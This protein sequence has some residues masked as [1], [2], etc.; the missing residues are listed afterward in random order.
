[1]SDK[2]EDKLLD[3]NYD[4]IEEYDNDL[5]RWWVYLFY[6]TIIF[7]VIYTIYYHVGG[8]GLSAEENLKI[9]MAEIDQMKGAVTKDS[10]TPS[11][12]LSLVKDS[13]RNAAGGQVFSARCMPCHGAKGEGVVGPNLTDDHWIHGGKI[14][15]I[16]KV[17]EEGVL[18]KGMLAWKGQISDDEITNVT[19]YVWNL[20]GTNPPNAKA[21]DGTKIEREG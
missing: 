17:I 1:M 19:I 16:K 11:D 10:A 6:G 4:G 12:L 20:Y 3:S 5:P 13:G 7:A 2:K 21:P 9:A 14:S 15:D 8:P 18:S